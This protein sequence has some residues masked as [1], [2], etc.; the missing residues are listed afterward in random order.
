MFIQPVKGFGVSNEDFGFEL[1]Q[2]FHQVPTHR[3][4]Q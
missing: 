4:R 2:F 3:D 1:R